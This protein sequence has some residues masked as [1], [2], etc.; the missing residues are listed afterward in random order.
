MERI[1]TIP[2]S[3]AVLIRKVFLPINPYKL[4]LSHIPDERREMIRKA[5][6]D[7][8]NAIDQAHDPAA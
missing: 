1:V 8:I 2:E 3:T 5:C 7:F 4:R 6:V